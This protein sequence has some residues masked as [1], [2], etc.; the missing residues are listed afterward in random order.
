M[1]VGILPQFEVAKGGSDRTFIHV[2]SR[3][4]SP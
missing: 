3:E 1:Q 4:M 2:A